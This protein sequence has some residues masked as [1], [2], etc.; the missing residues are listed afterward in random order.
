MGTRHLIAVVHNKQIKVAQYGQWDGYLEGQGRVVVE[1][2][3]NDLDIE[4]FRKAVSECQFL[5]DKEIKETW[6]EC[7]ADPNSELV[8]MDIA[9]KHTRKYAALSRDTGAKVLSLIQDKGARALMNSIDFAADSLFCEYAYVLDLDT[10]TLEI[11]RGFN[12]SPVP[13]GERFAEV[14]PHVPEHYKTAGK[15][16]EYYPVRLLTTMKFADATVRNLN[17]LIEKLNKE[18]E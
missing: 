11:Y 13:A 17:K 4:K 5:S 3:Q 8:S 10:E 18:E 14:Q 6:T 1:F 16:Y 7:G 12:K 15:T 2:I 9:D